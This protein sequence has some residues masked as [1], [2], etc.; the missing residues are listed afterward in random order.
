MEGNGG[1]LG[2]I[3]HA[4]SLGGYSMGFSSAAGHSREKESLYNPE[5]FCAASARVRRE[6][7]GPVLPSE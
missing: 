3:Q 4:I 5:L 1:I 7:D 6:H 2:A